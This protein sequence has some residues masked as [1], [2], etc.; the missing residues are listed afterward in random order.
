MALNIKNVEVERLAQELAALSGTSK[1]EAIRQALLDRK[2]R[3]L[4]SGSGSAQEDRL[5]QFL[6]LRVWPTIPKEARRRWSKDEE[7]EA[8]GYGECGQPE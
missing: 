7:D 6:K 8:L 3:L 1:T 5:L 2:E 4:V